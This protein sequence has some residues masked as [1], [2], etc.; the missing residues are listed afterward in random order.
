VDQVP[1]H[2]QAF[3]DPPQDFPLSVLVETG[4]GQVAAEDQVKGP[5][6]HHLPDVLPVELDPRPELVPG[7][8]FLA[9]PDEGRLEQLARQLLDAACRVAALPGALE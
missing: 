6:G 9:F 8:G 1:S 4:E 7:T 2:D 3:V 5:R